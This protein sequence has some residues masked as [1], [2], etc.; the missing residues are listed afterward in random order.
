MTEASAATDKRTWFR[1]GF[2][3]GMP[4]G[5]WIQLSYRTSLY[6]QPVRPVL[7]LRRATGEC[8]IPIPAALFGR[9]SWIGRVPPD[10]AELLISPGCG[11]GGSSFE[12][13]AC[14]SFSRIRLVILGLSHAFFPTLSSIYC[15]LVGD[16]DIARDQLQVALGTTALTKYHKWRERS[17]RELDLAGLEAPRASWRTGP[18][19]RVLI[20]ATTDG[21]AAAIDGTIAS[22]KRQTYPNWS[23]VVMAPADL[24]VGQGAGP[25]AGRNLDP[26]I[27]VAR[28]DEPASTLWSDIQGRSFIAPVRSGDIVAPY[29]LAA[30]AA[31]VVAHPA[32]DLIYADEDRIDEG[33][34][35]CHPKL[36][37]DWSPTFF[38][39]ARYVGRARFLGTS[40]LSRVQ[41]LSVRELTRSDALWKDLARDPAVSIGHVRRV[42]LTLPWKAG[43]EAGTEAGAEGREPDGRIRR[44]VTPLSA[45]GAHAPNAHP[46]THPDATPGATVIIPTRDRADLLAACLRGLAATDSDSFE[47]L[48]IDNGSAEKAT[49]EFY[50]SLEADRRIRLLEA[51]GKFNFSRLCNQAAAEARGR[52]LVFLNNDTIVTQPD[53]L[54]RLADWTGR[55][56]IG[57]VG[58]K[59]LYPSGRLQ[60][61]GL[62]L[63]LGGLA[64]H[65]DA[66]APGDQPG[67]LG[68]R[69]TPHEVAAVTGACLAVTRANFDSVG[70]FD[71]EGFPVELGDVDFCL[72]LGERGLR[73]V[74]A[75]D[76]VL[77]HHE[78]ASRGRG[79]QAGNLYAHEQAQFLRRWGA[80]LPDD[81]YFHPALSL[82]SLATMLE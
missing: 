49:W 30:L 77:V 19:V 51:P 31:F 60:H 52:V 54:S 74:V 65:I 28:A 5:N 41:E 16:R 10:A 6:G 79:R 68:R 43:M 58:A 70:G 29:A 66:G 57:V 13:E 33:G 53:W 75:T 22:L 7:R 36:K 81:P 61:C 17:L 32:V 47:V 73:T 55:P 21:S 71:S 3:G 35:H 34:R 50:R 67:Y 1:I 45:T 69:D 44:P 63:G 18:H 27:R 76:V 78:S 9:A 59:L 82:K 42:L 12:L 20:E 11:E 15:R 72:R 37:P 40:L 14:R 48:I 64:A 8:D 24:G 26:A 62:V 2:P 38:E 39:A 23:A 56:G 80:R 25:G 46:D 4:R